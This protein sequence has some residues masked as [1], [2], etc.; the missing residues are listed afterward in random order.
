MGKHLPE[1]KFPHPTTLSKLALHD[2]Y[3]DMKRQLSRDLAGVHTVN[4]M[5]DGWT[6][7]HHKLPYLGIRI[8]YVNAEWEYRI[9]TISCKVLLKHTGEAMA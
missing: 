7:L 9:A 8:A 2:A 1:V 4:I 6:D 3:E 5:F